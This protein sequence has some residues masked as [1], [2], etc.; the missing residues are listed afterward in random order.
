MTG[1][2]PVTPCGTLLVLGSGPNDPGPPD[3]GASDLLA[4]ADAVF[5]GPSGPDTDPEATVL[6][7]VEAWRVERVDPRGAAAR[8]D[9]WFD[10]RPASTAV[11]V[12]PGPAGRDVAFGAA[13][14]G[15]RRLRPDLRVDVRPGTV[16]VPPHRSPLPR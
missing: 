1:D 13:L 7:Y 9:A 12:V 2:G 10:A 3:P 15:L 11:L 8:L 4:T 14:D 6:F 16:V 5:A